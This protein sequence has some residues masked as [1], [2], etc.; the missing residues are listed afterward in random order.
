MS[1]Y[2]TSYA[3]APSTG[4]Q[5]TRPGFAGCGTGVDSQRTLKPNGL[6]HAVAPRVVTARTCA[7]TAYGFPVNHGSTRFTDVAGI[8]IGATRVLTSSLPAPSSS[9]ALSSAAAGAVIVT[10]LQSL[11]EPEPAETFDQ[12]TE[13]PSNERLV[14]S[15][16]S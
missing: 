16:N 7:Q 3:V 9:D 2:Q 10:A 1:G 5:R 6:L 14:A 12:K 11:P 15:S 4:A 8:R 13:L